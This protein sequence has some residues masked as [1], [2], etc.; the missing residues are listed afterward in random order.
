MKF[1][2]SLKF[3]SEEL[4]HLLHAWAAISFAFTIIL[5]GGVGVIGANFLPIFF[6]A[7]I[8]FGVAFLLH[9]IAHKVVAHWYGHWAE[10]RKFDWGL[11]LAVG[12]SFF[13]FIFAAPG[14]V[15]IQGLVSRKQNG[16]ISVVGPVVNL[17][18]A[19]MFL[20]LGFV[21]SNTFGDLPEFVGL[22][23][24]HGFFINSRLALFNMIPI[25]PLDGS[26]VI[27]WSVPIWFTVIGVSAFF[28]FFL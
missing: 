26:K 4:I 3:S 24:Y 15:M 23:L 6:I 5:G 2:Q 9:E 7:S 25:F 28:V 10:F 1:F 20:V 8:T 16:I 27:A 13:G 14:A 21:F 19:G 12:M 18:L 17:V 11:I 22:I